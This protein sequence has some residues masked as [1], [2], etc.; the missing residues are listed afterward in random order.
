MNHKTSPH[1]ATVV[2]GLN[3]VPQSTIG[4]QAKFGRMFRWLAPAHDPKD[5]KSRIELEALLDQLAGLMVTSEFLGNIKAKKFTN[6]KGGLTPDAPITES[7]PGDENPKIPAGYTYFGQFVDHDITFD[8]AS[9]LQ[10]QNDPDALEDF[11]TPRFDLDCIYG[12]GPGDQPYLYDHKDRGVMALGPDV[13]VGNMKRFDLMR[14]PD[15]TAVLGDKRNDENKIVSQIQALFLSFH[16][17]IYQLL[18][19][20]DNRFSEAQRIV[21]WCYQYIVLNDFLKRICVKSVYDAVKPG[22]KTSRGPNLGHYSAHGE[23]FIPVEFSVAAYRF[24]HSMVRPSYSLNDQVLHGTGI[25]KHDGKNFDF[26]RIPIF[27]VSK[28]HKATQ[29]MNGFGDRLPPH[30]GVDWHYFF[31]EI[32]KQYGKNEKRK[33]QPSY[34]IDSKLVDPLGDLPEFHKM[35]SPFKSLAY[36]N[37]LR[38][39][40]LGL[41]SGESIADM[42][43]IKVLTTKELWYQ[44]F[45]N[46]AIQPWDEGK[47]LIAKPAAKA[48]LEGNTP[49]WFYILKEAEIKQK[50]ECLGELGS[51]IVAETFYGLMWNDHYSYLFQQPGW[52]PSLE[53]SLKDS[54]G[55]TVKLPSNFDMAA[56]TE[57][58]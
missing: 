1:G 17:K 51:T 46:E 2:R 56:L 15:G 48:W 31:G 5:G 32:K 50:G 10:K 28:P 26:A 34:R 49:L 52:N 57:F 6:S 39:V 8:P 27:D 42:I 55:K 23:A 30:W 11:R 40:G 14:L 44:K 12:R 4:T 41:P 24:G 13:G 3:R 47:A 21:R 19:Y 29:A 9:S 35:G 18:P 36:R 20:G 22:G 58:M 45:D 25:F 37:L 16:N 38:G 33:P 54:K 43:G 7:E 53:T